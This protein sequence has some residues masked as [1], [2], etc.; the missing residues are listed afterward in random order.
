M[1]LEALRV[2][3][4]KG[5]ESREDI[6]ECLLNGVSADVGFKYDKEERVFTL[7]H[8]PM[9]ISEAKRASAK[10]EDILDCLRAGVLPQCYEGTNIRAEAQYRGAVS[11]FIRHEDGTVTCPMGR[12]LF[13]HADKK[14]GTVYSSREACRTCPNCCT[15]SKDAKTVSIGYNSTYV[16]VIMYGDPKY[17]LRQLPDVAR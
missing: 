11:C 14:Y 16:P 17:P 3:A 8:M 4:D 10:P 6:E 15:D 13:K 9:E 7:E 12:Q 1:G 2:V 5:D